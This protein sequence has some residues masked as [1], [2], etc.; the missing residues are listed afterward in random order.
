MGKGGEG[1]GGSEDPTA[2]H[3]STAP[4]L[5]PTPSLLFF[6]QARNN[7]R[8]AIS[9][10]LDLFSN[11]AALARVRRPGGGGDVASGNALFASELAAWTFHDRGL[12]RAGELTHYMASV[13]GG[14]RE[15]GGGSG[16]GVFP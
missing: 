9:G 12:L 10:S 1:G 4:A 11:A 2:D 5:T 16:V 14:G 8:V 7:A 6:F 3:P 15:G 13:G